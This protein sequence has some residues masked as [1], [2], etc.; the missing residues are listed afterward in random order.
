V[1]RQLGVGAVELGVVEVRPFDSG[2]EVVRD[3]AGR[4]AAEERERLDV[5]TGPRRLIH[6]QNR[7]QEQ[8]S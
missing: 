4:D 8:Q 1:A 7:A 5:R 2:L 3:Q 6:R